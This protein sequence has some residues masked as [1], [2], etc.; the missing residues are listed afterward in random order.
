MFVSCA[1]PEWLRPLR[2]RSIGP[3]RTST[4]AVGIPSLDQFKRGFKVLPDMVLH[5]TL[6]YTVPHMGFTTA[7]TYGG[8][9][10]VRA[11][12][13]A[14][15]QTL[16]HRPCRTR[17]PPALDGLGKVCAMVLHHLRMCLKLGIRA[18]VEAHGLHYCA[19]LWRPRQSARPLPCACYTT[20]NTALCRTWA[21]SW[22]A[23]GGL[24]TVRTASPAHPTAPCDMPRS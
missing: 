12:A 5:V 9:G 24:S 3:P 1:G 21:P 20:L 10:K 11:R 6:E 13:P 16:N 4:N 18:G 8:L 15:A 17:A 2:M 19:H 7:L 23:P 14:R 22:P